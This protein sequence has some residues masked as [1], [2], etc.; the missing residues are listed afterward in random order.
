[1]PYLD[2]LLLSAPA[3]TILGLLMPRKLRIAIDISIGRR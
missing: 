2:I 3:I 1:M